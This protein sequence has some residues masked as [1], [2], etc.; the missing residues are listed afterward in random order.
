MKLFVVSDI[1]GFYI[2]FKQAL[3]NAGFDEN[4][5][6]HLLICC[7]DYLDRGPHPQE[8][9]DYV[10]SLKNKILIKGNHE[11]L[12]RDC[13]SSGQYFHHDISNGTYRSIMCLALASKNTPFFAA[14]EMAEEKF[15]KLE[16]NLRNY[17]ETENYIFVHSW[18]P[19][20]VIFEGE[21][22]PWYMRGKSHSYMEDWRDANSVEW[23]EAMWGNPFDMAEN[24]LN[25]T[26]K[27][28]VFGHWHCSTGWARKEGRTE[29][30][31]DAIFE[32]YFGDGY[33]AIDGC[34]AHTGKC[35]V[36][37][38]EEEELL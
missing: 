20:Q 8:V 17:Y 10:T 14:C 35:N 18:I 28:I 23:E 36:L 3:E 22:K 34:T 1:H 12:M 21:H 38:I 4:N 25:Q 13:L 31:D 26:G 33:I 15:R 29:F 7:G 30:K 9:I 32:P 19:T 5:P 27:T 2:E 11:V 6:N 24:G 16:K 37:V